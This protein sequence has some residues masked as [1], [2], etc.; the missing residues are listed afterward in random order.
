MLLA[1]DASRVS[2][3]SPAA[4]IAGRQRVIV[5][6]IVAVALLMASIDQT[7]VAT[8]LGAIQRD[9]GAT[10]NWS[11]WTITI[12][13]L[14]QIVAKPLTGWISERYGAKQVFIAATGVFTVSSLL[15]SLAPNI[16]ALIV[17]RAVQ[18]LGGG[19]FVPC[20]TSIVA[21]QFGPA[22][23]RAIGLFASIF[24]IGGLI[25]PV[26]GGIFV[27]FGSWR[28]IFLV[29]VPI[30]VLLVVAG[31][32]LIPRSSTRPHGRPD[33][34]GAGLF[35]GSVL[36][37]MLGVTFLGNPHASVTDGLVVGPELAAVALVWAFV[38]HA[39]GVEA[40]F[41]PLRL[42]A[43]RGFGVVNL[44]N[45]IFGGAALGFGALVPLYA[46]ERYGI[47]PLDG[48]ALL[49][50]R[51]VGVILVAGLAVLAMRRTG[52][53]APII[54]GMV[55]VAVGMGGLA[56]APAAWSTFTWLATW[57]AVTGVGV[58]LAAP[59]TNNACLQLDPDHVAALS[60]L[61]GMFKQAGGIVA[62]SVSTALI[63][64]S[65]D[66]GITQAHL[67]LGY[68]ALVLLAAPWVLRIPDRRGAW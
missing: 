17:F 43:G 64:H 40:P 45:V 56:V 26:L 23:D 57:A 47:A 48:G 32:R 67:F 65:T 61:R 28:T 22:R 44:V 21:Q 18:A 3:T 25:G 66:P 6:G 59:A 27:T 9:L 63:A 42:L 15:C 33:L 58:G 50:A 14:G 1:R 39:R 20:A 53:R 54:G 52:Y 31:L 35:G 68:A 4:P 38:R 10:L 60:G 8:G 13:A 30:G 12:Y 11:G 24:P 5:F 36:A 49:S 16:Y 37:A 34:W 55:L 19:A 2:A 46:R 62:I 41:V 51:A 29:N 7:I